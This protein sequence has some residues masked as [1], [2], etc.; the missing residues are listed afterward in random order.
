[1]KKRILAVIA[2][3]MI[4]L[5]F[6]AAAQEDAESNVEQKAEPAS[7]K[8]IQLDLNGASCA[9]DVGD[10]VND[11]DGKP[12]VT[13]YSM[14]ISGSIGQSVSDMNPI[15]ACAVSDDG[16][17]ID[18]IFVA[19]GK[20]ESGYSLQEAKTLSKQSST[21]SG[22]TWETADDGSKG[23]LTYSFPVSQPVRKIIIGTYANYAKSN[24][25]A[26]VS[27][28]LQDDLS[29]E[30]SKGSVDRQE[31]PSNKESQKTGFI[32]AQNAT[33]QTIQFKDVSCVL[34]TVIEMPTG[35][36]NKMIIVSL[37]Y[38]K[39]ENI[40]LKPADL[41]QTLNGTLLV[42]NKKRY[43]IYSINMDA[44]NANEINWEGSVR[45]IFSIPNEV[46]VDKSFKL[47]YKKQE[48]PLKKE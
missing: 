45:V 12:S 37:K 36:L 10:V 38:I 28:D 22:G 13:I 19:G 14:A 46:K 30:D 43:N 21:G 31:N 39:D 27:V 18:P 3:S 5:P 48:L 47:V 24:Y 33:A 4:G 20:G 11:K 26:F 35:G 42:S 32:T 41:L 29:D 23:Y 44:N 9:V 17:I 40:A 7:V 6:G 2:A 8:T 25:D 1:M 15:V 34:D 16:K